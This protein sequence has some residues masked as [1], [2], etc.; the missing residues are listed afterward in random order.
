Q[1]DILQANLL[2]DDGHAEQALALLRQRRA[3]IE[4]YG[5]LAH[6]DALIVRHMEIDTL[7]MLG[8][9][10]DADAAWHEAERLLLQ[11]RPDDTYL[12][13]AYQ[14][15]RQRIDAAMEGK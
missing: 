8:R 4:R 10:R 9:I 6:N 7:L 12:G 5:G 3:D 15:L 13:D 11:H 1:A 2:A 14:A